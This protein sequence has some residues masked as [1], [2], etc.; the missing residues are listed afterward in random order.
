MSLSEWGTSVVAYRYQPGEKNKVFPS[1]EKFEESHTFRD[2][3]S[4]SELFYPILFK[5]F[6][7]ELFI[8]DLV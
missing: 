2:T 6:I 1:F 7:S 5:S 3:F 4:L 8:L